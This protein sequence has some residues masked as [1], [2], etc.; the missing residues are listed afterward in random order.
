M[1]IES[2]PQLLD[3]L[4]KLGILSGAALQEAERVAGQARETGGL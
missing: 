3:L 2:S 4:R 1:S